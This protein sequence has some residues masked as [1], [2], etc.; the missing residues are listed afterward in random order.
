M[1]KKESDFFPIRGDNGSLNIKAIKCMLEKH[2]IIWLEYPSGR[3]VHIM[4]LL[5]S[6]IRN[7]RLVINIHDF[8]VR[9]EYINY[10]PDG[11]F[12]QIQRKIIERLLFWKSKVIILP[13]EGVTDAVPNKNKRVIVM[14]PGVGR[15]EIKPPERRRKKEK[16]VALYF[17]GLE[18]RGMMKNIESFSDIPDWDLWLLGAIQ[19]ASIP[20]SDNIKYLGCVSHDGILDVM[21]KVD[22][23][24]IPYP[25]N[26]YLNKTVPIKIGYAIGSY[27]P[28]VMHEF[29]FCSR[30]VRSLGVEDNFV[31]IENWNPE[32]LRLALNK[33]MVY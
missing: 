28:I 2:S 3:I 4:A 1:Q 20:E 7:K 10:N 27:K 29:P 14:P 25:K 30:Y 19:S 6:I 33:A 26:K 22:V 31:Y 21:S 5:A 32:E 17:G 12:T 24:V 15:D 16:N 8:A 11:I 13:H 23:I 18:R 9:T